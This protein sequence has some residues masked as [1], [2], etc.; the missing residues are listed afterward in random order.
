[1]FLFLS[2]AA[3]KPV[4]EFRVS[5]ITQ[6]YET[7]RVVGNTPYLGS[8]QFDKSVEMTKSGQM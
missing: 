5:A 3:E 6:S 8:W 7:L 1:M 4:L 2:K